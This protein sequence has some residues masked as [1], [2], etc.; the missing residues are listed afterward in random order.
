MGLRLSQIFRFIL[1]IVAVIHHIST[2]YSHD[3]NSD[4][5]HRLPF[6]HQN[7]L[8]G[9]YPDPPNDRLCSC[10]DPYEHHVCGPS[11]GDGCEIQIFGRPSC[12]AKTK[13]IPGCFC[14]NLRGWYRHPMTLKCVKYDDC[15]K[16]FNYFNCPGQYEEY[17]LGDDSC[18]DSCDF[19][20]GE[21]NC[22]ANQCIPGCY[23]K[24]GYARSNRHSNQ[25]VPIKEC[26]YV[27]YNDV[28]VYSHYG[29]CR[30]GY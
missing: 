23:C 6:P 21:V 3:Y 16:T 26:A 27:D 20:T 28:S 1:I 10:Q 14:N 8:P 22:V 24:K 15:P 17:R 9:I 5:H 19:H 18:M 4:K 29:T 13:C 12:A 7:Y 30:K 11:Y 25:C 2:D